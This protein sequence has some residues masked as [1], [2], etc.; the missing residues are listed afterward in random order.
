M[1]C[2]FQLLLASVYTD[3]LDGKDELVL[4]V[5][6]TE[7]LDA[8]NAQT[9]NEESRIFTIAFDPYCETRANSENFWTHE[10]TSLTSTRHL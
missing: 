1:I 2:L 3:E 9:K 10:R 5:I 4:G 7:F 8:I 6:S